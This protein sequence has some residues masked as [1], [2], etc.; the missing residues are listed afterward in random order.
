M[1]GSA[2]YA[3]RGMK[4]AL[5]SALRAEPVAPRDSRGPPALTPGIPRY[6]RQVYWWAYVHPL[7]VRLF[8]REWL[9]NL[10]LF[11]NYA[12]LRDA[13]LADMGSTVRGRTLQV[14]CVYGSLTVRLYSRLASDAR[15]DVVDILPIQ[16]KNLR[17]KLPP[18]ARVALLHGDSSLLA[19]PDGSYDQVLLFFLLHEQPRH[20]R[21]RTLAEA[22]R[23]V[24]PGGKVVVVDYHR[25]V[26]W[27]PLRPLMSAVFR[28]LEPF[29][30]DLWKHPIRDFMP[31]GARLAS[32]SKRTYFGGLYQ[33]LLLVR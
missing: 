33:K 32:W 25:P 23:V 2:R 7:A 13:A 20:V 26:P 28:R 8:E 4:M 14:A 12:R 21:S 30:M 11:G 15:L 24:R 29:A 9:V 6:L 22:L 19:C 27:H 16:L 1:P 3:A 10:I 31:D 5:T 18:D 17:S